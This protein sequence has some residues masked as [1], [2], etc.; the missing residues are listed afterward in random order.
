MT[1]GKLSIEQGPLQF[2]S[3]FPRIHEQFELPYKRGF[4]PG[5]R[6]HEFASDDAHPSILERLD[7]GAINQL[8]TQGLLEHG[9]DEE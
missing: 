9:I 3:D 5:I 7:L 2:V 8:L 6:S 1:K 4:I